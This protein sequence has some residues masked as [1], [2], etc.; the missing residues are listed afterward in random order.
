MQKGWQ[1][2]YNNILG[3]HWLPG[4][5]GCHP[6][7]GTIRVGL[8]E[9]APALCSSVSHR[10]LFAHQPELLL[11]RYV[12]KLGREWSRVVKRALASIPL[13]PGGTP[14]WGEKW[15]QIS[16][17]FFRNYGLQHLSLL[18]AEPR[19]HKP[20]CTWQT[21]CRNFDGG[22]LGH[23]KSKGDSFDPAGKV[24]IFLILWE[25]LY[26]HLSLMADKLILNFG[27]KGLWKRLQA[28]GDF[29]KRTCTLPSYW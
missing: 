7:L 9:G 8:S 14:V 17:F 26:E 6:C 1:D 20:H 10:M 11:L 24:Q 2:P 16:P 18:R 4:A 25:T 12:E 21:H 23:C 3:Q 22:R 13:L 29:R 15:G 27:F 19:S 5:W 28:M